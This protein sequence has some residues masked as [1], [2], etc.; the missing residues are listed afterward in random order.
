MTTD[1]L[2]KKYKRLHEEKTGVEI[3]DEDV[4]EQALKLVHLVDI[5]YKP[6][7]KDDTP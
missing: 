5:V 3:S 4:L 2:V 1:E 6:I 7:P